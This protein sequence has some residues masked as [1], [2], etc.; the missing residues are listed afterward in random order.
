M[1]FRLAKETDIDAIYELVKSAIIE[2]ENNNIFQWDNIYPTKKDFLIDIKKSQLFV[3]ESDN[4]ILVVFTINKEY[5]EQYQ[6]G[7]WKYP[8]CEYR[9]IHRLCVNPKFQNR[10]IA[11]KTLNHI[12]NELCKS[13]VEAIRLDVFT[14]NPYA[15]SLYYNNGYQKAGLAKWRK[16]EFVLMEKHL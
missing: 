4:D 14:N 6:N 16:G 9:V 11:G 1:N 5:D 7:N 10:G 2:M 8:M 3:G 12:E 13:G 15:L